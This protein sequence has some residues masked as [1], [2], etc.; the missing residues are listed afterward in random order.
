MTPSSNKSGLESQGNQNDG[1]VPAVSGLSRSFETRGDTK[2]SSTT[3]PSEEKIQVEAAETVRRPVAESAPVPVAFDAKAGRFQKAVALDH[4]KPLANNMV[5]HTTSEQRQA[6]PIAGSDKTKTKE[7]VLPT[8]DISG[9]TPRPDMD[10]RSGTNDAS[11]SKGK[12]EQLRKLQPRD[13]FGL[14]AIAVAAQRESSTHAVSARPRNRPGEVRGRVHHKVGQL[15]TS[16]QPQHLV[17]LAWLVMQRNMTAN[18]ERFSHRNRKA[19]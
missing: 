9:G 11:R 6:Q 2:P 1:A 10:R 13:Q 12:A 16:T 15:P 7:S 14:E 3:V 8:H 19:Q 17:S 4:S 18:S 5:P